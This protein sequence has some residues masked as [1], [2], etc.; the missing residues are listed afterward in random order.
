MALSFQSKIRPAVTS[1]ESMQ[2][3]QNNLSFSSKIRPITNES[4]ITPEPKTLGGFASNVV[5]SGANLV[6]GIANTLLHPVD[7]ITGLHNLAVGGVEKLIPGE[8]GQEQNFDALTQFFKDRYGSGQAIVDTAYNDPIGFATDLATVFSGGGAA[9]TKLGTASKLSKLAEVGKVVSKTG[10]IIDPISQVVKVIGRGLEKATAGKTLGG[11][12]YIYDNIQAAQN[13]GIPKE[14]LPISTMTKSPV[15]ANLEAVAAKGVGG[16][17]IVND[18]E[19]VYNKM[20]DKIDKIIKN[21][22]SPTDLGKNLSSAVDEFKTDFFDKKR[23]LYEKASLPKGPIE[24]PVPPE[25]ANYKTFTLSAEDPRLSGWGKKVLS[26]GRIQYTKP[27][28]PLFSGTGPKMLAETPKTQ[29]LLKDLI[30]KE[31]EALKGSGL[32]TSPE[33]KT[34]EGYLNGLSNPSLTTR[35]LGSTLNRLEG[36]LKYNTLAKTGITQKLSA[37]Q[38]VMDQEFMDTLIKQRPDKALE[39]TIADHFMKQ[40]IQKINSGVIQAIAR[41]ADRPDIIV[42]SLLPKIDSLE[43]IKN[44]KLIVGDKNM[45]GIRQQLLSDM[46]EKSKGAGNINLQPAGIS[47]QIKNFGEDKLQAILEPQQYQAVKDLEK[48]SLAM[49]RGQKILGGSQTAYLAKVGLSSG[50][51]GGALGM[52]LSGNIAGFASVLSAILGDIAFNKFIGSD[53]GKRLLTEGITLSGKTGRKIQSVAP[54]LGKASL[55]GQQINNIQNSQY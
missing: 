12:K 48:I 50:A 15:S 35:E 46:F 32:K 51:I 20:N 31:K 27:T 26:D 14:R 3:N 45:V 42:S 30:S 39:L 23:K 4:A 13:I 1:T 33:L 28:T 47:R 10:E 16:S 5:S 38:Q 52:L 2:P 29:A 40:G 54:A 7:T 19:N 34:Y 36:D 6:G 8:Q 21:T 18:I 25:Y 24:I 37:I 41:N 53:F 11:G 49:A 44:L 17:Q 9:V 22:P 43:D 55:F